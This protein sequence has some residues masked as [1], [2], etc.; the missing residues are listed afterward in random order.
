[1]LSL[2]FISKHVEDLAP[3]SK[4]IAGDKADKLK[5]DRVVDIKVRTP[6]NTG[7]TY[8]GLVL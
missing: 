7:A 3:L 1:M 4:V 6:C 8:N 5:L 2:G